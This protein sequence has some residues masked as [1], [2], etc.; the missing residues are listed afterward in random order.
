[1]KVLGSPNKRQVRLKASLERTYERF[2]GLPVP[3]VL[4]VLWL[5]GWALVGWCAI[6]LYLVWQVLR[7]VAGT[8]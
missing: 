4:T 3:V 5:G 6:A 2:L 8:T 1:V 7:A